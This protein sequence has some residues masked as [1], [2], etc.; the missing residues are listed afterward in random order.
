[1]LPSG[2]VAS[3]RVYLSIYL[4]LALTDSLTEVNVAGIYGEI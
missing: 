3:G 4:Y 1:M 2:V